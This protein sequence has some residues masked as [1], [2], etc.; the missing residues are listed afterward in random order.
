MTAP[1][2]KNQRRLYGDLAWTWP[3]ISSREEYV[4]ESEEFCQLIRQY[5][6][7][8]AKTLLNL[9]CGGGHNDYTLQR[10]LQLT[11]VDI[12]D[13]MLASARRL[14]SDVT[15]LAGD[16]RT[17]RL[18][19]MFDAVVAFDSISYMLT[20]DELRAAFITA[21]V[22]LKPGGV[23]A[24][25]QE[26]S[27]RTFE[28]NHVRYQVGTEGDVEIVFIENWYDP[29]PT[30]STVEVTFVYLIRRGGRLQIETDRHLWGIFEVET[31]LRLLREVGFDV[32]HVPGE[33]PQDPTTFVCV[34]PL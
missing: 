13:S 28:Q 24:T 6:Q 7:I 14:N 26:I 32:T 18:P 11:S 33:M 9:G 22:H 20:C 19:Q 25:Y 29:D 15:Y 12:S 1:P 34:K 17:L 5:S 8:E 10:H 31:W 27:P 2:A 16:M 23:F 30:D 21:F 4:Q 3:I